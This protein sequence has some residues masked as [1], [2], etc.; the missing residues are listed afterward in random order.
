MKEKFTVT[1]Y[2]S[3]EGWIYSD[4]FGVAQ[5]EGR[6]DKKVG[7][8]EIDGVKTLV[9]PKEV[10]GLA[11]YLIMFRGFE[12]GFEALYVPDGVGIIGPHAFAGCAKLKSVRVPEDIYAID[13]TAF[14]GTAV[15][16][17]RAQALY[18]M[19]RCRQE[20]REQ[21]EAGPAAPEE[22]GYDIPF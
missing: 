13:E 7:V 16:E 5:L 6:T 9:I 19:G 22:P 4:S 3:D 2:V 21:A 12:E 20:E 1:Y 14:L 11:V 18:A 8:E 17:E 15:G 10:D